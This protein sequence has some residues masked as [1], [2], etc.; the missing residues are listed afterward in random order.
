MKRIFLPACV[1][2]ALAAADAAAAQLEVLLE[3]PKK[4]LRDNVAAYIGPLNGRDA[5][6]LR[7]FARSAEREAAQALQ[8]LG[9]YRASIRSEVASEGGKDILRLRIVAGEP[10]RLRHVEIR[11]EGEAAGLAA[12]RLPD[13]PRL[14]P[15][16]RLDH[17]AYEDA[18]R[19][20]RNQA[21][22][23]GFF[24]GAFVAQELRVDPA[25]GVADIR[26]VYRS[27]PR[28]RLGAVAFSGKTPF[29]EALLRRLVPFKAGEPYDSDRLGALNQALV[30][31]GYFAD[32]QVEAPPERAAGQVIPVLVRLQARK[33]RTL[34]AGL[35]FSTDVGPRLRGTWTRHWRAP[36]GHRIG[37]DFEFS[38]PRQSLSG[39]YEIP[40]DPPLTD[41]LRFTGGYQHEDLLDTQSRRLTLGSQWQHA[42]VGAW[43]RILSLRWEQEDYRSGSDTGRTRLLLPGIGFSRVQSDSK[44]DPSHGWRLQAELVGA[45]RGLLSDADLVHLDLQAKGLTSFAGGHRLLGRLQAG[46]IATNDFAAIPPSLRFFAGGDQSVRGYDYQSLSP[47]DSAG[48]R[49]GGRYLLVGSVEYQYPLAERWRLATFVDQG[50][51]FD[52]LNDPLQTGVGIGLRWVSPVGPLRLDLAHALDDE[53]GSNFRIHFS[54]GPEL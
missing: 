19:L 46:G 35:G 10:V 23:F 43:Q 20:I 28:Y 11:V 5:A 2:L 51:A 36:S 26:L 25:A 30:S 6:A 13:S 42:P 53:Q 3:P 15:G 52:H 44:V 14:R 9:Y 39:W 4:A 16:A 40:L 22:R 54:M 47:R 49:V 27:G 21:Q 12:L 7:R 38:A 37:S 33:P 24:D 32:V 1:L 34:A 29:D 17:G 48:K 8:A 18:K 41:S 31:S 45:Q 50:N